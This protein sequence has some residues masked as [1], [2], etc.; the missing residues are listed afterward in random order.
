MKYSNDFKYIINNIFYYNGLNLDYFSN[1][2][3]K[4]NMNYIDIVDDKHIS[5]LPNNKKDI[6]N[7]KKLD[8]YHNNYRRDKKIGTLFMLLFNDIKFVESIVLEFKKYYK[9]LKKLYYLKVVEGEE[10]R[11]WY[12]EK[13]NVSFGT[14]GRSCMRFKKHQKLFDFYVNNPNC[15]MLILKFDES[16]EKII[17]RSLLW[18][19]NK[20]WYMDRIYTSYNEDKSVFLD[21]AIKNDMLTYDEVKYNKKKLHVNVD[22]K[23]KPKY[24]DYPY[25]DTFKY[26]YYLNGKITNYKTFLPYITLIYN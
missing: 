3:L 1:F 6:I 18:K 26:Y 20:G 15:K 22:K 24:Y 13:N 9:K 25:M 16:D 2:L 23:F 4:N 8:P 11:H 17:G 19:T 21:Y 10:I 7:N 12:N 14:L 5:Y